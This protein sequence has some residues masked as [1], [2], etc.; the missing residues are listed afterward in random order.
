MSGKLSLQ[1]SFFDTFTGFIR[2][3]EY[4]TT[5]TE[6]FRAQI[7]ALVQNFSTK[8]LIES[9]LM[10]SFLCLGFVKGLFMADIFTENTLRAL[11]L[12]P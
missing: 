1:S 6:S 5:R 11:V 12:Q 4:C 8:Y 9:F 3:I 10:C 7:L 2:P